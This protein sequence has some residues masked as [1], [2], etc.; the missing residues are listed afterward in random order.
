MNERAFEKHFH[1]VIFPF[2]S[3]M[4]SLQRK[5]TWEWRKQQTVL[6]PEKQANEQPSKILLP[7]EKTFYR[8]L[9]LMIRQGNAWPSEFW[10]AV[11]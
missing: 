2:F 5:I 7:K 1:F 9:R 11:Y 8:P 3:R 10:K 4:M 6:R